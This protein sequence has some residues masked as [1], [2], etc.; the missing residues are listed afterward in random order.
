LFAI[1]GIRGFAAGHPLSGIASLALIALFWNPFPWVEI[2]LYGHF[3]VLVGL[4]CLGAVRSCARGYDIRSG[5]SLAAGVL[6]KYL[7]IVLLPF[8]AVGGGRLR[9]RVLAAALVSIGAGLGLSAW[10]W[11]PSTFLP[12]KLAATRRSTAMSIF[13]FLRGRYS[14]LPSIGVAPNLDYLAPLVQLLALAWAWSWSRARQPDVEASAV[15]AVTLTVLLYR[16]GFPQ[17][18]MVPFVLGSAWAVRHWDRLRNRTA[19]A[20]AMA[21]YFGWL[22]AFDPYYILV[23][24]W[25]MEL[26]WSRLRDAVGLPTFLLGCAFL[27]AVVRASTPRISV[28]ETGPRSCSDV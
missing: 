28:V 11:G 10:V 4:A 7:P 12:L 9:P 8:L 17:Y 13:W 19:L 2:A 3:D 6:L 21:A 22:A 15:V 23:D 5:V 25:R 18:Q 20:V 16:V 26:N 24:S 27:A 1:S 14:P